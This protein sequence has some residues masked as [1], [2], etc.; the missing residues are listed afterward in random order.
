MR[1][2][3]CGGIMTK[4]YLVRHAEA[5][6]NLYRIAQGQ[7]D[8]IITDRGYR[9][10][11]ALRRRFEDIPVN[12]VYSSDLY[13][14]CVTAEAIYGPKQL[15]LHKRRDLREIS[16]GDWEQ[17]TWG[18]LAREDPQQLTN[19]TRRLDRWHVSGAETP[20][21]VRDRVLFAVREIA[22][23]NEGGTAAVFSHGCALR[24]LLGTLQ[25]YGIAQLGETSHGDNTAVSL[26][27]AE[28][29]G[30]RVVFRDDVSHLK[31]G[32]STFEKQE[33][34]K[35]PN[36]VEPGLYFRRIALPEQR[37]FLDGCVSSAWADIG[38]KLSYD[39]ETLLKEA[40]ARPTLAALLE[41]VPVGVLQLNPEKETEEGCGWISLYCMDKAYRSRG[42]G[43]QLLGQAVQYYRPLGRKKLR[44]KLRKEN[45][46]AA[47]FFADYGFRA[48]GSSSDGR[49][50]WEKD[51]GYRPET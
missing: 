5:E 50:V 45:D 44:L 32:L 49:E 21:Q 35:H 27:E 8:S 36:A 48:S 20:E 46:A 2:G 6:G 23:Q 34:W 16:V 33:W 12:A 37:D 9:Q 30:L 29:D 10:I 38:G 19:F 17:K 25:G 51:I 1:R 28:G 22:A 31:D 43:I 4:I 26:L 11:E 40:A 18:E 7:Y 41:E 13:R 24:I 47:R 42:L 14:C 3:F 39:P 15:P